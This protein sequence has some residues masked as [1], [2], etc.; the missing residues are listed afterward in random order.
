[1]F[2]KG[3]SSI[4]QQKQM[5]TLFSKFFGKIWIGFLS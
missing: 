3:D 5:I 2:E 4:W 1:M